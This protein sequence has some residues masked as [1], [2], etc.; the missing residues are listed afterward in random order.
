MKMFG[1]K[2]YFG[3]MVMFAL[4]FTTAQ[5]R[6]D[7]MVEEHFEELVISS[8]WGYEVIGP[9]LNASTIFKGQSN[10]VVPGV[11]FSPGLGDASEK[12]AIQRTAAGDFWKQ[13]TQTITALY[14]SGA[15]MIDFDNPV[16]S[17]KVDLLDF[18]ISISGE[19]NALVTV[20]GTDGSVLHDQTISLNG[21]TPIPFEWDSSSQEKD[22]VGRVRIESS[23]Y[24]PNWIFD[25]ANISGQPS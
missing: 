22:P 6:A 16:A 20:Y 14:G 18:P 10:L 1:I 13:P 15:I 9:T 4:L 3:F 5:V 19:R 12:A 8:S 25:K 2:T 7:Y 23:I 17:F 11:T 24:N 21:P